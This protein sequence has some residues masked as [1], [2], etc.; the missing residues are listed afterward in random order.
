MKT[1]T[2]Q[3]VIELIDSYGAIMDR[4]PD[5]EREQALRLLSKS[6]TLQRYFRE[7]E[8]ADR[9]LETMLAEMQPDGAGNSSLRARILEQTIDSK[10]RRLILPGWLSFA[11]WSTARLS[12]MALASVVFLVAGLVLVLQVSDGSQDE[13]DRWAW[14]QLTE[15]GNGA[16]DAEEQPTILAVLAPDALPDDE[17]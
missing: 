3:R 12:G 4:W 15:N 10:P 13:F 1:V 5:D 17:L 11:N 8:T 9:Q 14:E 2:E 6:D 7:S 16:V